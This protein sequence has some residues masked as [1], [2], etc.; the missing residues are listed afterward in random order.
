MSLSSLYVFPSISFIFSIF[1]YLLF[2]YLSVYQLFF[3]L[4]IIIINFPFFPSNL[5]IAGLDEWRVMDSRMT[6]YT[7]YSQV[8]ESLRGQIRPTMFPSANTKVIVI[9]VKP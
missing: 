6:E 5:S 7:R 1:A 3:L 2:I 8:P 4:I 9:V